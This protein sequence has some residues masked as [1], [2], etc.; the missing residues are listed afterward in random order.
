MQPL[1]HRRRQ[2]VLY[3][4]KVVQA[5]VV[6]YMLAINHLLVLIAVQYIQVLLP[7]CSL[8]IQDQIP[9]HLYYKIMMG[10]RMLLL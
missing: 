2:L 6:V 5:S 8:K 9:R 4:S 1:L 3:R 7:L 10:I